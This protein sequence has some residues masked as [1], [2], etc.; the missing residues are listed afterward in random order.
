MTLLLVA[1]VPAISLLF[2]ALTLG[3]A[4]LTK[5]GSTTL[6]SLRVLA[7][8]PGSSCA[9]E[10]RL[11][12]VFSPSTRAYDVAPPPG[13]AALPADRAAFAP[14]EI[15]GRA[16]PV[17]FEEGL[18]PRFKG[19]TIGQWQH[20]AFET[21]A[22][23]DLGGGVRWEMR[24]GRVRVR[25]GSALA[26]DRALLVR[27]GRGGFASPLGA[28]A[29]GAEVEAPLDA[30]RWSPL[31]DLGFE[32]RS[33]GAR[34]LGHPLGGLRQLYQRDDG[35]PVVQQEE[36]LLCVLR[37]DVPGAEIDARLSAESR[38]LSL[39]FVRKERP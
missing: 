27:A 13:R 31:V 26:I 7:S 15:P 14:D 2:L 18:A 1:T 37:D 38:S 30:G 4:W 22:L 8:V 20:W 39:L 32:E 5:G 9:R 25:N 6:T 35:R 34:V 17:A 29:P 10:T 12:A 33:L 23:A 16:A 21:R 11:V 28:V 24:D 36:F 3:L 19:V